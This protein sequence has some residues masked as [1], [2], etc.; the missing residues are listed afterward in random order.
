MKGLKTID[1]ADKSVP[2]LE[3]MVADER[4]ALYKARRDLVFRQ[5]T[6][7]KQL[8]VR[9]HNIARLLTLITQKQRGIEVAPKKVAAKP[10]KKAAAP[11]AAK[12]ADAPKAAKRGKTK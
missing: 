1:V 4:A 3:A 8:A 7:V 12:S 9:R 10:A 11:K 2:E 6:D 5:L